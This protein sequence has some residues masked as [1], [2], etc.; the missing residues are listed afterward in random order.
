[1]LVRM[2]PESAYSDLE[3]RQRVESFNDG[4]KSI[5]DLDIPKYRAKLGSLSEFVKD[6]KQRFTRYFNKEL[7]EKKTLSLA[8]AQRTQRG[9]L[10]L[11]GVRIAG[12]GKTDKRTAYRKIQ[13]IRV[14]S[15][16]TGDFEG[17]IGRAYS[18]LRS[19]KLLFAQT[20]SRIEDLL[21]ANW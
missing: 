11:F 13:T 3:V 20:A 4:K 14:R 16:I 18:H 6:I 10:Y 17:Q 7:T 21:V 1:M 15:R 19:G 9:N 12:R 2:H 8:E 5:S